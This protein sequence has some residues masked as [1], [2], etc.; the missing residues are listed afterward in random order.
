MHFWG[1][2]NNGT[3]ESPTCFATYKDQTP[4]ELASYKQFMNLNDTKFEGQREQWS[5]NADKAISNLGEVAKI[6][7]EFAEYPI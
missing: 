1:Y 4:E 3:S 5:V 6:M 7:N 2:A